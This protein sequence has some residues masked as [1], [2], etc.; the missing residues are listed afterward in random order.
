LSQ[1]AALIA[2]CS[3][4]MEAYEFQKA[5]SRIQGFCSLELSSLVFD[6]HKDTLYTLALDDPRRLSAQSALFEVLVALTRLSAPVLAFTAEEVWEHMDPRWK[7]APSVHFSSW[8][9]AKQ[10]WRQSELE[11]D[12]DLILNHL[13]PVVKKKLEEA[14]AAK[15]IG[16]PY[17]AKVLLKIHSKKLVQV[18]LKYEALLPA[19]FIV[20]ELKLERVAPQD[21]L[22]VTP[23]EVQVSAS[24]N[25]KCA[26]CWRRPGDV[27]AE[28]GIC[29]RCKESLT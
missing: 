27:E 6:I 26:R 19:W 13:M 4:A 11:G 24:Q 25:H 16:H 5:Y 10:E 20:S 29:G 14:R 12:F 1:L 28:G 2:D 18:L 8:P 15:V 17:D 22:A 23:E 9:E 3:R 7:D 21:G